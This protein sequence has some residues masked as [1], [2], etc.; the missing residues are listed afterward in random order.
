MKRQVTEYLPPGELRLLLECKGCILLIDPLMT[1]KGPMGPA[2]VGDLASI[3]DVRG[4]RI[5]DLFSRSNLPKIRDDVRLVV[6]RTAQP[7]M[8]YYSEFAK[9][10]EPV[11][12]VFAYSKKD[13]PIE[14][15][16]VLVDDLEWV[17]A[18]EDEDPKTHWQ[19]RIHKGLVFR[20]RSG[21]L[22]SCLAQDSSV[23]FLEYRIFTDKNL[24]RLLHPSEIW[25]QYMIRG[26]ELM[27]WRR[28]LKSP[29]A[30]LNLQ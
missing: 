13:D 6:R 30:L 21:R 11:N 17:E 12:I 2:R 3:V 20:M 1:W 5:C 27:K 29:A 7:H 15:C 18:A 24:N 16:R 4:Q 9:R 10:Q 8:D 28:T 26:E 22:I 23:G 14:S 25:D 19:L